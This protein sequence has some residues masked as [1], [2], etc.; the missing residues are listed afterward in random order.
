MR[1]AVYDRY[2]TPGVVRI[3]S[4]DRPEP[5]GGEVLVRVAAASVTAADIA[6]RSGRPLFSRLFFGVVRPKRQILGSDFSGIV[7]QVGAGVDSFAIGDQVWGASGPNFGSHAELLTVSAGGAIARKPAIYS[8][9][10]AAAVLYG[11]LTALP[12][13]RDAAALRAGQRILVN[14]ASGGVGS[15]AVQLAKHMGAEVTAV[16]SARNAELVRSL[17]ADHVID[18]QAK[19]FTSSEERW[20][21]VFDA[22]GRSSYGRSRR[23]LSPDGRYLSTV[24][25][26]GTMAATVVARD[27]AKILFTGMLPDAAVIEDLAE[28]ARLATSGS[29]LPVLDNAFSLADVVSAHERVEHGPKSGNVV[30]VM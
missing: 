25:S 11:A 29:L 14:G 26:I 7:E 16:C 19:D 27:R 17:G 5:K 13:L 22:A 20:D 30:L 2:G 8:H 28:L 12:F 9:V 15:A 6:A 24:P 1:A 18:Y 23:V 4:R 21:V 3:V 10:D